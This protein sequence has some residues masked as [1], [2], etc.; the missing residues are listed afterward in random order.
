M[1]RWVLRFLKDLLTEK[2][3]SKFLLAAMKLLYWLFDP[4]KPPVILKIVPEA[5]YDT[6]TGEYPPIA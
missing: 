4:E 2:T 6:F 5:D 1:Q 3:K